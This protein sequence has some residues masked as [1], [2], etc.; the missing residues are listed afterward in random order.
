[1]NFE[2]YIAQQIPW[3]KE[4]FGEGFRTG[5]LITHIKSELD[6]IK[7]DPNNVVEWIDVIILAIDGAWR[8]GYSPEEICDALEKKQ[9]KNFHRKWPKPESEDTPSYHIKE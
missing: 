7:E 6:E 2:K 9:I 5:G 3:S 1:M 8:A 4:T